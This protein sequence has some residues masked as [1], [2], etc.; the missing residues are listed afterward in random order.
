YLQDTGIYYD[1]DGTITEKPLRGIDIEVGYRL[2]LWEDHIDRVRVLGAGYGFAADDVENVIGGRVRT[3]IDITS[4]ISIAGRYQYDEARGSQSFA[5]I[6]FRF[7]FGNKKSFQENGL[8]ARMDEFSERDID[9]VTGAQDVPAQIAVPVVNVETGTAQRVLYVDNSN[10]GA[11]DGSL[12][13]PFNSLKTAE[14][15]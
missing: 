12:E 3:Q 5:D 7:P 11:G 1:V 15:A 8:R 9:I 2:P 6:T 4:D 14:G 10:G 13:N